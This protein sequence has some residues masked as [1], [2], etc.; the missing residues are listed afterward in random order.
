MQEEGTDGGAP[1]DDST[2]EPDGPVSDE[3][4]Y[5]D[6]AQGGTDL[7]AGGGED[8][9]QPEAEKPAGAEAGTEAAAPVAPPPHEAP[10][11]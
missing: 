5:Q 8:S 6:S 10:V 11:P 3:E 4:N 2:E 1:P 9:E 7:G